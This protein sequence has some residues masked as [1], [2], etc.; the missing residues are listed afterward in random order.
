MSTL[1]AGAVK[2]PLRHLSIRVPWHDA[3]WNGTICRFPI[4]NGD[5]LALQRIRENR[6]DRREAALAG[7]AWNELDEADLPACV[8]ERGGFMGP[9]AYTRTVQH[10]YAATSSAHA[11]FAP[12][13]FRY[14]AYSAACIPFQWMLRESADQLA[15]RHQVGLS[16]QLEARARELMGFPSIWVQE[17]RNQLAMLDTF[18]GAVEPRKSLCF[19]YAKRVP[20]SDDPRRVLIGVG[21]ITDVGSPVE[22]Q[23]RG[24]G[25]LKSVLWERAVHHSIRPGFADGFL[26]PYHAIL[27]HA[28]R[29]PDLDTSRFVAYAPEESWLEFSYGSEHVSHDTAISALLACADALREAAAVLPGDWDAQLRWIDRALN[30]IWELRGPYP[31][32]G[33]ALTAFGV[34]GGNFLA[35]EIA[36]EMKENEDLWPAVEMAFEDPTLLGPKLE[37]RIT[38]TLVQMWRALPEERRAL[39]KLLSRFNLTEDQARRFYRPSVREEAGITA[40]DAELLANPYL[41][42]ELDRPSV[43]PIAFGTVDRGVFPDP[44]VREVHPLPEPSELDGADDGRRVRALVVNVLE[45][46]VAEAGDTLQSQG[47]GIRSIG[48]LQLNPPCP[49]SEDLLA[50]VEESFAP[51]IERV[52]MADGKPAY[53]L[54]RLAEV[55]ALIRAQV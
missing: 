12:T 49:V 39:L 19:F 32:L 25:E 52:E 4:A 43:D 42:Y 8:G 27:E 16:A 46:A 13:R 33:S 24:E 22:Y 15:E 3:A 37:R 9:F 28:Q 55:R 26:L 53:Q 45:K 6:D 23:Y 31:G 21:R 29:E 11:H 54:A 51:M 14:P 40:G 17:K 44:V 35:Y 10:P 30:E 36:A 2:L 1:S 47:Q 34:D 5:C 38:R 50:V 20:L 18:F 7:R 41:L 48:D